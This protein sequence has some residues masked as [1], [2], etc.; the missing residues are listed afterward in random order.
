MKAEAEGPCVALRFHVCESEGWAE[1][2]RTTEQE[3]HGGRQSVLVGGWGGGIQLEVGDRLGL[4]AEVQ[5][6]LSIWTT[7]KP[8]GLPCPH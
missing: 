4:Q 2:G 6:S 5:G 8:W 3:H 1:A 7:R